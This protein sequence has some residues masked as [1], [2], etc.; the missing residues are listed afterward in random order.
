MARVAVI[1]GDGIGKEVIPAGIDV[2]KKAA[3]VCGGIVCRLE[4]IHQPVLGSRLISMSPFSG[5][6]TIGS[7]DR[8]M[9]RR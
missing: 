5:H 7:Y 6:M 9:N 8:S 2:V 3:E 1:A 4:E